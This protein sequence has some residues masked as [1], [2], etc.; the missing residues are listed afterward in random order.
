MKTILFLLSVPIVLL[1]TGASF[2]TVK[3]E[4][5]KNVVVREGYL[6][7]TTYQGGIV[8]GGVLLENER[9]GK[10]AYTDA[11]GKAILEVRE[12]DAISVTNHGN[13]VTYIHVIHKLF[14]SGYIQLDV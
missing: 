3:A 7:I 1:L 5:T 4:V 6:I 10:L 12:G 13:F 8:V 2:A 11:G 9:T 14:V